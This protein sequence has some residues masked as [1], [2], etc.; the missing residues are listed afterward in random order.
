MEAA[1][2]I[3]NI[4]RTRRPAMVR[5][6]EALCDAYITLANLDSTPWKSQRSKSW[7]NY[8]CF[9]NE[10]SFYFLRL[11]NVLLSNDV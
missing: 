9:N 5:D 6:I 4:V 1:S 3:I 10:D 2:T 11:K 8:F 7:E